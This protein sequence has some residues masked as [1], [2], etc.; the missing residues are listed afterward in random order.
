[1][2]KIK[3]SHLLT[4]AAILGLAAAAVF[5]QQEI[6]ALLS[7]IQS[8]RAHPAVI[9]LAFL[10]LPM[11]FFPVTA[12]LVLIGI[13]FDVIPGLV[14]V[15]LLIPVHLLIAFSVVRSV[16][17]EHVKKFARK[18]GYPILNVPGDRYLEFGLVFMAV[19]GL[20]YAVKNYLLP[21]SGIPF[22]EYFLI[23]WL[24]N[25]MLG[26]PF[27]VLGDAAS[28]WSIPLFFFFLLLLI[29]AYFISRKIRKRY[30]RMLQTGSDQ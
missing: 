26:I 13:R 21:V 2:S 23:S 1:M 14:I 27:V 17:Y 20:P 25:G 16:L 22:R 9:V 6:Q 18:K 29:V 30:D 7:Y 5:F 11:L 8:D 4:A 24:V 28:R 19:P 12:L 15:F 3:S 10:V